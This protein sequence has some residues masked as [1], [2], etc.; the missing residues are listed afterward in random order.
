MFKIRGSKG[1]SPDRPFQGL[2]ILLAASA[3]LSCCAPSSYGGGKAVQQ[4]D[5]NAKARRAA[6]EAAKAKRASRVVVPDEAVVDQDGNPVKFYADLVK[7]KLVVV[8]FF[9]TT[10]ESVCSMQGKSLARLQAALGDQLGR[11]VQLISVSFDPE[12]DSPERLKAWGKMFGAKSG[13]RL[14]T[15]GKK[16]I[17]RII[18]AFT[19]GST[20]KGEHSAMVFIGDASK[21]VWIRAYGLEEPDRLMHLIDRVRASAPNP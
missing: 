2:S 14:I 7:G 17:D 5:A 10:C 4:P 12:R 20:V 3:M 11:E 15:G 1:S 6:E 13:W 21:G 18:Q 9:Y 8:N 19:G 16:E